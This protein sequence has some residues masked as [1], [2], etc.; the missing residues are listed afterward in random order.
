MLLLLAGQGLAA[1]LEQLLAPGGVQRLRDLVLAA[2]LLHRSVAAQA[3]QHD[4][5]LLLT[6][7]VT[8][9]SPR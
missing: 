4:L 2:D 7:R 3:G 9:R 1:A 5:D 8:T 6:G